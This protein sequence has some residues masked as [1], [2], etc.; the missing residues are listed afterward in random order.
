M[1]LGWDGSA[2]AT[3]QREQSDTTEED[4]RGLWDDGSIESEVIETGDLP[5]IVEI[6]EHREAECDGA[7]ALVSG[8]A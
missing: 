6:I 8:S 3:K 7:E 1:G 4:G 5:I 2:A